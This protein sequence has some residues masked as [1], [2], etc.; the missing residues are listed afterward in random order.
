MRA[1][2]ASLASNSCEMTESIA[3]TVNTAQCSF[4]YR[5]SGRGRAVLLIHG[6]GTSGRVW[7]DVA[8]RLA[9]KGR[10]VLVPDRPGCGDSGV[11]REGNG[12]ATLGRAFVLFAKALGEERVA[13]V[14]HGIGAFIAIEIAAAS[15]YVVD[16]LVLI[17]PVVGGMDGPQRRITADEA[18]AESH[19]YATDGDLASHARQVATGSIGSDAARTVYA[20]VVDQRDTRRTDTDIL[21]EA[22][23]VDDGL[24][25][26]S[27][28]CPV[29]VVRGDHDHNVSADRANAIAR[30]C[31]N[32]MLATI[33]NAGHF[34][35]IEQPESVSTVVADFIG[36]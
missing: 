14:G 22:G 2:M 18:L 21:T 26:R 32:A 28:A 12:R 31:P 36:R 8:T 33:E 3:R 24:L 25:L 10:R 16:R 6:S 35:H 4:A 20:R 7:N 23:R 13:V 19:L 9:S 11:P 15:P 1:K 29:L 17:S 5:E 34:A 27:L 30:A